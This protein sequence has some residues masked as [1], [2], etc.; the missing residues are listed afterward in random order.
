MN[1]TPTAKELF[2]ALWQARL[3][4]GSTVNGFAASAGDDEWVD[5]WWQCHMIAAALRNEMAP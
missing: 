1:D 2:L 5:L 4:I 3:S